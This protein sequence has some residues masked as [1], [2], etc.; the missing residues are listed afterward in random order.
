MFA[1][2]PNLLVGEVVPMPMVPEVGSFQL[3][4]VAGRLPKRIPPIFN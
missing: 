1:A 4:E 3:V 2:I